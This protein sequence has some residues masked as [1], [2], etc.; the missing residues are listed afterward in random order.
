MQRQR[1]TLTEQVGKLGRIIDDRV[2]LYRLGASKGTL[3]LEAAAKKHAECMDIMDSM[4]WLAANE[5]WIRPEAERR[6]AARRLMDE[7][8]EIKRHPA[9]AAVLEEFPGAEVADI[10]P[11]ATPGGDHHH[12]TT[13]HDVAEESTDP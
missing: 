13:R 5:H 8:E 4:R 7:A 9:V 6:L 2:R 11:L 3:S 10:R 12:E 1:L